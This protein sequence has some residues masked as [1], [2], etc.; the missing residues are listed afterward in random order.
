MRGELMRLA[1]LI[2]FGILILAAPP[3]SGQGRLRG[4]VRSIE[5]DEAGNKPDRYVHFPLPDDIEGRVGGQLKSVE[6]LEPFKK[7]ID[8]A[9][10]DP[11]KFKL[12][13][14]AI[15]RLKLDDPDLQRQVK[16]WM[17]KQPVGKQPSP[18]DLQQLKGLIEQPAKIDAT[19]PA[20]MPPPPP[21][22]PAPIEPAPLP[23]EKEDRFRDWLKGAMDQ[24]QHSKTGDS[25]RESPAWQQAFDDLQLSLK[26]APADR[27]PSGLDKLTGG[28]ISPDK[29]RLPESNPLE[30]LGKFKPPHLPQWNWHMPSMARPTLPPVS[31]PAIPSASAFGTL[32]AWLLGAAIMAVLLWQVSRWRKFA[33]RGVRSGT[34]PLGPWPVDPQ[35]VSS[36]AELVQAFDYLALSS[37]GARARTW[38]HNAVA[39][40]F[41][42]QDAAHAEAAG[43]LAALYEQARYIDDGDGLA[44]TDR[45]QARR[46]LTKLAGAARP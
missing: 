32:A 24:A 36:R 23:P 31:A 5:V 40:S 29:L 30:S 18:E 37:L 16:D 45:D 33:Q 38:N 20:A 28:L 46:L 34:Q 27:G 41:T 8:S 21:S 3:I 43:Q 11:K 15:K 17:A 44:D 2:A 42:E 19:P 6:S 25:L 13:A 9:L 7:L 4:G 10:S 14:E 26:Q 1:C 12:D 22:A 35:R 39:R